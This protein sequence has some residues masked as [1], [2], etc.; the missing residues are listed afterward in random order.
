MPWWILLHS[1]HFSRSDALRKPYSLTAIPKRLATVI[2]ECWSTKFYIQVFLQ[3]EETEER[4]M[5]GLLQFRNKKIC[6]CKI[7]WTL[8]Q[9]KNDTSRWAEMRLFL[10]LQRAHTH[11]MCEFTNNPTDRVLDQLHF[12]FR[13]I[14]R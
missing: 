3:G 8:P 12:S 14:A 11:C 1:I 5:L 6:C 10:N 13:Q 7:C 2:F 9:Y 4:R